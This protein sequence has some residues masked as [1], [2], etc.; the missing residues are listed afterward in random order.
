[1]TRQTENGTKQQNQNRKET[2]GATGWPGQTDRGIK[3]T[4]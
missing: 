3:E 4:N 1:M 2:D